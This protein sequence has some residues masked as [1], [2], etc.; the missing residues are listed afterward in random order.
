MFK[1]L[2]ISV[3]VVPVLLGIK[4]SKKRNG[5]RG[6]GMLLA[7]VLTYDVFYFLM[8]YYLRLRWVGWGMGQQ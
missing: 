4:A 6:F 8:L 2:M 3:V 5:R 1:L 7:F